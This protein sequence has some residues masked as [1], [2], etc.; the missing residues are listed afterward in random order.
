MID[1]AMFFAKPQPVAMLNV[2]K[3]DV[4]VQNKFLSFYFDFIHF[5][6]KN[7]IYKHYLQKCSWLNYNNNNNNDDNE[8]W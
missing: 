7:N 2:R 3:S 1:T 5:Y 4:G 8:K 6:H